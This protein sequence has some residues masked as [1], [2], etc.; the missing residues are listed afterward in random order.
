MENGWK[1][2]ESRGSQ[3]KDIIEG[4]VPMERLRNM[5]VN[6]LKKKFCLGSQNELSVQYIGFSPISF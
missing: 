4:F 5:R 2:K 1:Q 3:D 6:I